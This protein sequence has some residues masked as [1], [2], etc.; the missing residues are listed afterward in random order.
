[1]K[2]IFQHLFILGRPASGKSEFIDFMKK[3]ADAERAGKFHIGK[4]AE[5]DDFLWIWEKFMEDDIW[6]K[7]GEKRL[8][9]KEYMPGNPG[10]TPDAERLLMFCMHKFNEAITKSYLPNPEFYK[11]HTLFIEFAR[12]RK[13]AY[14]NALTALKPEV[15]KKS[16]ILFVLTTRDESW[17]RNV[18]R[19]QEKQKHSI[20]AHMVP[21][22]TFGH[23]YG[24]H[25]W[26]DITHNEQNGYITFHNVKIP[27]VTMNNEPESVDP[28]VL[29]P[30]YGNALNKLWEL[31]D[32]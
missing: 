1:M 31:Y 20:L 18:A 17:R 16:A 2:N 27:F 5:V 9:S 11:D 28:K 29:E 30:R 26:L 22:E 6:E 24:E 10:M 3:A 25:D 13:D 32:K 14:K 19:Y 4:F 12:G 21:K 23:F 7:I 8:Y 15:L